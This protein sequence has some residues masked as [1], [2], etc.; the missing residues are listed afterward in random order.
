ME[1]HLNASDDVQT[2]N[3]IFND[4]GIS[5]CSNLHVDV[6]KIRRYYVI[7]SQRASKVIGVCFPVAFLFDRLRSLR[8]LFVLDELLWYCLTN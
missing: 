8:R 4:C 6:G 2:T 5:D 7:L 1:Q 3:A